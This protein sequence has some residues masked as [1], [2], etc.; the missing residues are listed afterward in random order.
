[1]DSMRARDLFAPAILTAAALFILSSSTRCADAPVERLLLDAL[2][3]RSEMKPAPGA[4]P[5][6][7][8]YFLSPSPLPKTS[9][10]ERVSV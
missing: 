1:M 3:I 2:E 8:H 4:E 7:Q 5:A 6:V 9:S 10:K